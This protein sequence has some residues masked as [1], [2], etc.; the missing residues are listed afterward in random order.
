MDRRRHT[1]AL[2][3]LVTLSCLVQLVLIQRATVPALDAVRFV[4]TARRI[5]LDGLGETLRHGREEPLF[6]GWVWLVHEGLERAGGQLRSS[7]A[8]SVQLAAA[9][10]LVLVVVPV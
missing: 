10:P 5:D 8:K 2:A 1:A 7:W 4:Q 3:G 9:I 6:P